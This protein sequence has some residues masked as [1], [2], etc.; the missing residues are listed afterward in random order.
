MAGPSQR[1]KRH[2]SP[3]DIPGGKRVLS[4]GSSAARSGVQ[5]AR[6]VQDN[7]GII[8]DDDDDNLMVL[9]RKISKML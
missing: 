7:E 9:S 3:R 4:S 2:R 5:H 1:S 6:I 8:D